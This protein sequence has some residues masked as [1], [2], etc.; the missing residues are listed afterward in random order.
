M[1]CF[2]HLKELVYR[3]KDKN[4]KIKYNYHKQF[5]DRH[6]DVKYDVKKQNMAEKRKTCRSF[7]KSLNLK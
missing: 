7:K 3:L 5:R 1:Q 4:C 6:E 2:N